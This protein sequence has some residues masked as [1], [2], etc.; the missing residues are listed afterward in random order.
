MPGTFTC[1]ED[2][3]FGSLG[4]LWVYCIDGTEGAPATFADY[5]TAD[6]AGEGVLMAAKNGAKSMVVATD[7]LQVRPVELRALLIS[8]IVA[9]KTA[10][11][12][13]IF[14]TGTDFRDNVQTESIDVTAGNGTYVST[15]YFRTITQI[16]CEDAGDGSGTA[17]ADGTLRITQPQWGLVW[18]LGNGQYS[19]DARIQF[20]DG[21]TSS[22][23]RTIDEQ[24]TSPLQSMFIV[25]TAATMQVGEPSNTNYSGRGSY[26]K[27]T[28]KNDFA[29][30]HGG[31]VLIYNSTIV[32][33]D[34]AW[35]GS[36]ALSST[37]TVWDSSIIS[38]DL[39]GLFHGGTGS[40][41]DYNN[42]YLYNISQFSLAATP[43]HFTNVRME[44]TTTGF[45]PQGESDIPIDVIGLK[46]TNAA[47]KVMSLSNSINLI[48]PEFQP[49]SGTIYI[50]LAAGVLAQQYP[51]NIHV[52]DKGGT[53][54]QSVD[55]LIEDTDSKV[56]SVVDSETDLNEALDNSET[57]IDVDDGT[58]FSAADIIRIDNEYMYIDSI[59]TNTLTVQ[60]GYYASYPGATHNDNTDIYIAKA[61]STDV[62]GDITELNLVYKTW[63]T[64]SETLNDLS[65]HKFTLSK[66][67]YETLPIDNYTVDG[68]VNEHWELQPIRARAL[69]RGSRRMQVSNFE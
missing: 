1:S 47:T 7:Y 32:F 52:A 62:S 53:S 29:S 9:A 35:T 55:V 19:N 65:P 28:G 18:D 27:N 5:V 69:G 59:S 39:Q 13:F 11:A 51:C 20:G 56:V 43:I 15:K 10:E 30:P 3:D 23:F 4:W 31:T 50:Y 42:V 38:T 45:S 16:D 14:I 21:S 61:I 12:D 2:E 26:I 64:T 49:T 36:N 24:I 48:S 33:T 63:S 68:P 22:Y 8:F 44:K 67:G 37:I 54:L 60:R 41:I 25:M 40:V 57:G 17:W 34:G 6:R 46:I 58:K 66:A